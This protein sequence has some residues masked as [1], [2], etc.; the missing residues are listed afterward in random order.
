MIAVSG[1]M[2][3]KALKNLNDHDLVDLLIRGSSKLSYN[4]NVQL[5]TATMNYITTTERFIH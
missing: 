2:N 3:T 1:A 4:E 5:L